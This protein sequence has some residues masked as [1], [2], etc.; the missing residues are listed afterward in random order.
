MSN[1][2]NDYTRSRLLRAGAAE[3]GRGLPTIEPGMP[4]PA[5]TG[6]SRREFLSRSA[7]LALAVYGGSA[8]SVLAL[9]DGIAAAPA[10]EPQYYNL[11]PNI[12]IPATAGTPF[13]E[14]SRLRWHPAASGLSTLHGEGK[15]AA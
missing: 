6:L 5:G 15:V 2:C 14:D 9:D 12:A 8:L 4:L 11:R 13:A 10:G 7:G 3:A 1:C